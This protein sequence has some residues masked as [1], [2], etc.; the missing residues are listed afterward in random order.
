MDAFFYG[1]QLILGVFVGGFAAVIAIM[2]IM[3][4]INK[5]YELWDW[6]RRRK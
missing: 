5:L 3:A 6:L 2:V 1:V 4:V